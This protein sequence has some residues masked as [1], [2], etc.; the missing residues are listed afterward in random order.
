MDWSALLSFTAIFALAAALPGPGIAAIVARALGSGTRAS[1]PMIAGFVLGDI[2]YLSAAA[3]GL[4]VLAQQFGT[5]FLVVR[6]LGAIYL[7]YL[8]YRLWTAP[9][10][11][12]VEVSETRGSGYKLFLSGLAVTLGNPKVMAFYLAL[13]PTFIDLNRLSGLGFVELLAIVVVVLSSVLLAYVYLAGRARA[14]LTD[15]R[16]RRRLNRIAGSVM[17]GAAAAI[18]AK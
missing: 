11:G 7:I 17:A 1:L 15:G 9:A 10:D 14:F 18:V 5:V 12:S 3:F 16:A 8:A 2:F 13:L 4:A 6:Y